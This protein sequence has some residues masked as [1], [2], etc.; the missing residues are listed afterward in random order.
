MGSPEKPVDVEMGDMSESAQLNPEKTSEEQPDKATRFTGL[1]KEELLEISGQPG[2]VRAR[3]LLFILFWLVWVGMLVGAIVIVIQAPRC[4]PDPELEWYQ[5]EIGYVV[6]ETFGD[7][8]EHI[9]YV[10]DLGPKTLIV[11]GMEESALKDMLEGI[12]SEKQNQDFKF[13]AEVAATADH[14]STV[15]KV[16]SWLEAGADGVMATGF[17]AFSENAEKAVALAQKLWEKINATNAKGEWSARALYLT[18]TDETVAQAMY[19][20]NNMT[21]VLLSK[22][23]DDCVGQDNAGKCFQDALEPYRKPDRNVV[24]YML[25]DDFNQPDYQAGLNMLML[26]LPGVTI[27]R[28]ADEFL[29]DQTANFTWVDDKGDAVPARSLE[30]GNKDALAQYKKF[31]PKK[32]PGI[33]QEKSLIFDEAGGATFKFIS[34]SG[35]GPLTF[36]RQWDT[37][38]TMLVVS[39]M[40]P[41]D[42]TVNALGCLTEGEEGKEEN[43]KEGQIA[44]ASFEVGDDK[45]TVKL[46]TVELPSGQTVIIKA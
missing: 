18:S 38:P 32:A 41:N 1:T 36:C 5:K 12:A 26:A 33:E 4:K 24:G 22:P 39:N 9:D 15:A 16:D 29:G 46:D 8:A 11:K 25:S 45:G 30:E 3:W 17:E 40:T 10:K 20:D 35:D 21:T 14:E 44:D 6:D 27:T 7:A 34:E 37:K 13:I 19:E 42:L 43:L 2:W 28:S 31:S 23:F